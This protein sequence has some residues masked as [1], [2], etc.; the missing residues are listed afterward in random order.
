[1]MEHRTP[2][3]PAA[4][5][6][7]L[8]SGFSDASRTLLRWVRFFASLEGTKGD[9]G[10]GTIDLHSLSPRDAFGAPMPYAVGTSISSIR[11]IKLI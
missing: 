4:G 2:L 11:K 6:I 10:R 5:W 7:R 1:M 8:V 3:S 9:L